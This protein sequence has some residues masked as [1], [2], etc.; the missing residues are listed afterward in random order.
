MRPS[1]KWIPVLAAAVVLPL[2][3][4]AAPM[5]QSPAAF[6]GRPT[7]KENSDRSYFVWSDGDKWHVRWTTLGETRSFTGAV[8]GVGGEL[9]D[10]KRID[11]ET[12]VAVIRPGRPPHVV[13]GPAGRVRGVAPGRAPV[14]ATRVEDAITRVDDHLIRWNARTDDIDGFDFKVDDVRELTFDL[15]I[16]GNSRALAVEIG[17]NNAHPTDNPFTVRLR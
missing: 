8:R 3:L 12:E 14:V 4:R 11:V 1:L 2:T 16:D 17:R 15:K 13:R 6:E 7:F 9:K 5:L 10:L